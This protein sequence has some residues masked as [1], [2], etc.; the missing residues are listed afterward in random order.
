MKEPKKKLYAIKI[1]GPK[2][3]NRAV[4]KALKNNA[5]SS[6]QKTNACQLKRLEKNTWDTL[7]DKALLL[8]NGGV[9]QHLPFDNFNSIIY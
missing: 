9:L 1:Y 8:L 7:G 4:T 6:V 5:E 3:H 2:W